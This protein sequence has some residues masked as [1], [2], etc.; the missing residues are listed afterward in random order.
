MWLQEVLGDWF[1]LT[2]NLLMLVKHKLEF[3]EVHLE[4]L[5]LQ[6]DDSG[7]FWDLDMLSFKALSFTDELE[8]GN[9]EVNIKGTSVRFSNNESSLETGLSSFNLFAPG[10]EK[11]L[12]VDLKLETDGVITGELS[13]ELILSDSGLGELMNRS[14]NLLE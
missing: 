1:D 11:P 8:N 5:F 13:L 2:K 6:E 9:I 12:L 10:S 7:S 14:S 4:F 3:I